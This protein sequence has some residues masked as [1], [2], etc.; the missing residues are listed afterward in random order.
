MMHYFAQLDLLASQI[1]VHLKLL[2][3]FALIDQLY[4]GHVLAFFI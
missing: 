2:V 1:P 4:L 3:I